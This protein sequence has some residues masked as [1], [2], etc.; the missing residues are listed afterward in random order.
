M[1]KRDEV[2]LYA[3]EIKN[4]IKMTQSQ[5]DFLYTEELIKYSNPNKK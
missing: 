5:D 3:P 1:Q 4:F 2:W